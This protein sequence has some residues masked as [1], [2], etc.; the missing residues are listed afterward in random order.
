MSQRAHLHMS[1]NGPP[2]AQNA[3]TPPCIVRAWKIIDYLFDYCLFCL[4]FEIIYLL[5]QP[6]LHHCSRACAP[7]AC[8][9]GG[10]ITVED[11]NSFSN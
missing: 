10:S 6:A 2:Y 7:S 3:Y 5:T 11:N 4:S 8:V 9:K 1:D